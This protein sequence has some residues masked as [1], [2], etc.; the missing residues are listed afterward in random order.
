LAD[1]NNLYLEGG[2]ALIRGL[3]LF[4]LEWVNIQDGHSWVAAQGIEADE[5]MA[6]LGM[7]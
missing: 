2:A 7:D 3:A 5:D 4:D 1:A 6:R